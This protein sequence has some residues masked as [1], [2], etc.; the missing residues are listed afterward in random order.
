M[1]IQASDII[2]VTTLGSE[3]LKFCHSRISVNGNGAIK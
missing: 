2:L 1:H 3:Q